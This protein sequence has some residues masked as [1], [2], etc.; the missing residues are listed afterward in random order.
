MASAAPLRI[1]GILMLGVF[2]INVY[3][4]LFDTTLQQYNV[5]HLYLNWL[6][7]VVDL[8]AAALLL[9]KPLERFLVG[10]S[11]VVWPI[12]YIASIAVDIETRLCLGSSCLLSNTAAAYDYLILGY[13]SLG[14]VLW[15]YTMITAISLLSAILVISVAGIIEQRTPT[16]SRS[17]P[18]VGASPSKNTRD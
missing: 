13:S 1:S 6:M 8:I 4:G 2:L 10:L 17:G 9:A 12:V 14:W 11:G 5:A 3:I 16:P 15:P 18:P 7:A